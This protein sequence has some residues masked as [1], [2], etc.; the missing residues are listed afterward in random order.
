MAQRYNA[1]MVSLLNLLVIFITIFICPLLSSSW[2]E[3]IYPVLFLLIFL[4]VT[5]SVSVYRRF[6]LAAVGSF[7][8]L[9]VLYFVTGRVW[10]RELLRILEFLF[11]MYLLVVMVREVAL[12]R[13][14]D[15]QVIVDAVTGYFL[16]GL[17]YAN[18][19]IFT[20]AVTEGAYNI[21]P[22]LVEIGIEPLKTYIYYTFVTYTT[23]GY[24]DV[25][26]TN[27]LSRS[28]AMLIAVSGQLY[29]AVIIAM[30]VGK[31]STRKN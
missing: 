31:Y 22:T 14:V 18:M 4:L 27:P 10:F 9:L 15:G 8:V 23:T 1:S 25:Y 6:H 12:T 29:I 20:A 24:G 13:M 11:F 30:L 21:S 26:P 16:L 7:A 5:L 28:L 3:N 19:V 2:L 17:G